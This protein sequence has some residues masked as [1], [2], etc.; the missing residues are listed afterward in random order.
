MNK[1][2]HFALMHVLTSKMSRTVNIYLM[3]A[4]RN[5]LNVISKH[6]TLGAN[7]ETLNP[8]PETVL[9]CRNT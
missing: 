2:V 8:T 9:E 3:T 1:E 6:P 7:N 5:C 4:F